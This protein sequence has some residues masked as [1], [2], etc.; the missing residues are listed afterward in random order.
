M[1]I[2]IGRRELIAAL[3]I[4]AATCPLA[5]RAQ[6]PV[7]GLLG[8]GSRESDA[9]RVTA[10]SQGEQAGYVE[11]ET[12]AVEYRGGEGQFDR[13]PALV[14]DLVR[15]QVSVIATGS[16]PADAPP[17]RAPRRFRSSSRWRPTQSSLVLSRASTV[18][19]AI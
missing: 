14:A 5:A 10:L 16:T 2:I 18:R 17:R 7:V 3:G 6:M 9:F 12:V 4:A 11:G 1:T 15:R 8:P 13:F 19:A